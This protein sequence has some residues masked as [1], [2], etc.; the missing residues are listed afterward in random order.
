MHDIYAYLSLGITDP[1]GGVM[2]SESP[3]RGPTRRN[4]VGS[5]TDSTPT[6]TPPKEQDPASPPIG[7]SRIE[8]PRF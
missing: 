4:G 1:L 7:F 2:I 6:T 3:S 8:I 5:A